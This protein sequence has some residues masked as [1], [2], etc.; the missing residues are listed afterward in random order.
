MDV[1][2]GRQNQTRMDPKIVDYCFPLVSRSPKIRRTRPRCLVHTRKRDIWTSDKDATCRIHLFSCINKKTTKSKTYRHILHSP[3]NSIFAD[4]K[5]V[6]IYNFHP[7]FCVLCDC[8][9]HNRMREWNVKNVKTTHSYW[10]HFFWNL[11]RN[12]RAIQFLLWND[13]T[14]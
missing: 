11:D 3:T 13:T 5:L 6:A 10:H 2:K 1:V 4:A 9:L 12:N 14:H 8:L 7:F